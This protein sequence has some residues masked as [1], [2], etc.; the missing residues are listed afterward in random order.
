MP[1]STQILLRLEAIELAIASGA[2]KVSYDG[3]TVDFGSLSD[4]RS[5]RDE[6]RAQLGLTAGRVRRTVATY[7]G[8]FGP[9]EGG[10]R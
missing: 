5:I 7:R 2:T 3:K 4:L 10:G 1:T 8:G 9:V 6:L